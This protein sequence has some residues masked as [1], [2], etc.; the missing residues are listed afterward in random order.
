MLRSIWAWLAISLLIVVWLPLLAV[1]RVFDSDPAHYRTGYWFRRLGWAMTRVNPAWKVVISG[2]RVL[3]PRRPYVVVS[4][5]QSFADIPVISC[6]PWEMKWVGKSE[7]FRIPIVG[8]MMRLA[9]DLELE[10]GNARSGMKVLL[11]ARDYLRKNCSVIFFPEGTRSRDGSVGEFNEGAFR[12][13][14]K[15]Q[16]PVL[17]LVVE[18]TRD[19]LPRDSWRFG[20]VSLIRVGV[21]PP[22]ET[23]GLTN[24]DTGR[25]AQ[26]VRDRIIRQIDAWREPHLNRR[27]A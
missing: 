26:D 1:N 9:G 18:G 3:D 14:I 12:L 5:H 27:P 10:R 17:P 22:I 21:L 23:A 4:N 15:E 6:L 16:V 7:L 8:W 24:E 25:L 20:P 2:Y 19:A 13:A 11:G